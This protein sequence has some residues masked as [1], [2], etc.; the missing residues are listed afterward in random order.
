MHFYLRQRTLKKGIFGILQGV[1]SNQI[2]LFCVGGILAIFDAVIAVFGIVWFQFMREH[3]GT[4]DTSLIDR[5]KR[6]PP[7]SDPHYRVFDI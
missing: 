4:P 6:I 2:Q 3:K 7:T 1:K 5:T